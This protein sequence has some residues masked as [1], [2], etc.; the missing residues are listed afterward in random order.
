LSAFCP[1][2]SIA[3][4]FWTLVAI[5]LSVILLPLRA[6]ISSKLPGLTTFLLPPL[7]LHLRLIYSNIASDE[8]DE[9]WSQPSGFMILVV[10]LLSPVLSPLVALAS[11]TVAFFWFFSAVLGDPAGKD[12][13]NDGKAAVIAVRNW[14]ENWLARG[15]R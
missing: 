9:E 4:L 14:W 3:I 13:H 1:L 8:E 5:F 6:I 2:V 15:L 7:R 10:H 11:W 12:G